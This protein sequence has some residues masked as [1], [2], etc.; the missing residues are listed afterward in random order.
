MSTKSLYVGNLAFTATQEEVNEFFMKCGKV[1][2][3]RII[4]DKQTGKARG[5]CFVE[6]SEQD[7]EKAVNE[8]NGALFKGRPLRVS[9]AMNKPKGEI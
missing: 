4:M 5:F 8:L 6:M 2:S 9:I 3:V 1:E 7:C